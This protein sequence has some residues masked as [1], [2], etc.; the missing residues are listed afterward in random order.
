MT[1]NL[2]KFTTCPECSK[3]MEYMGDE[4]YLCNHCD[5]SWS[6]KELRKLGYLK[7]KE[8]YRY[9]AQEDEDDL[10]SPDFWLQKED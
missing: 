4:I 6:E 5:V 2:S 10:V 7:L 3:P 8:V 9:I 1:S